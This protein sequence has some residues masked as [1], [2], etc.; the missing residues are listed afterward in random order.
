MKLDPDQL[1][2]TSFRTAEP[3]AAISRPITGTVSGPVTIA[4]PGTIIT[5][6]PYDPTAMTYCYWCPPRTLECN[7]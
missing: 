4:E 5:I 6:G 7:Y 1:V 3:D 2:V